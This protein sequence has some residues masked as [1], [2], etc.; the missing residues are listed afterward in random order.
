MDPVI[1]EAKRKLKELGFGHIKLRIVRC[2]PGYYEHDSIVVFSDKRTT[3]KD[4]DF[5][6]K[7]YGSR[8]AMKI[9]ELKALKK[10]FG[11]YPK[12]GYYAVLRP[13]FYYVR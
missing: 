12:Y 11:K 1:K 6:E 2:T 9:D 13:G 4:A 8:W 7:I 5:C 10:V 3:K